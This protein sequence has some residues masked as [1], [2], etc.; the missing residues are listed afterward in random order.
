[1]AWKAKRRSYL[2]IKRSFRDSPAE[3]L[4]IKTILKVLSFALQ[5]RVETI[6]NKCNGQD[7]KA[8]GAIIENQLS[9]R[10]RVWWISIESS[11]KRREH[12][13]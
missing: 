5:V 13:G 2:I 10:T 3:T 1:L 11:R 4:V 9:T 6:N 7:N 12:T 8:R